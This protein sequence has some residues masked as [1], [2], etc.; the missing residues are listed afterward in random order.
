MATVSVLMPLY[1]PKMEYVRAALD[2][3][4][5]QTFTDW[6]CV[7]VN[8]RDDRDVR[9]MLPA[10]LKDPRITFVQD[11]V[12]R[13]IGE[14]WNACMQYADTPYVQYLF[15]DDLWEKDYLEKTLQPFKD[16]PTVGFV[17]GN[18]TYLM[19]GESPVGHIYKEVEEF[20]KA[21]VA[22]GFHDGKELLY[23]WAEKGLRPNIIGEPSFVMMKR[24]LAEK[25][26]PF[27][28]TMRQYLD[29]EY[30]TRCLLH[31]DWYDEPAV[32]GKFR[33]H[34]AG[35]SAQNESMGKGMFERFDTFKL[36][37]ERVPA[38]DRPR[39]KRALKKTFEQMIDRYLKG[40]KEGRKIS[41]EGSGELKKFCL[42]HPLLIL[43]AVLGFLFS[44]TIRSNTTRTD[45]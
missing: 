45:V 43:Q 16:H 41:T 18:H 42:R 4:L 23:W 12:D 30:W 38:Q 10:Y 27:H 13:T 22:P 8:Q 17:S 26:G 15:Y 32:V 28:P 39:M 24:E 5:A 35:A 19:E 20:K 11:Q 1:K 6:K 34:P 14:N 37:L 44:K 29:S 21:N 25:A 9:G 40:K 31:A 7:M 2:C 36:L 3:L 33:V